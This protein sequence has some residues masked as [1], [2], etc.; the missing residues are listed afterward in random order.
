MAAKSAAMTSSYWFQPTEA[1]RRQ[2]PARPRLTVSKNLLKGT[3]EVSFSPPAGEAP[4]LWAVHVKR[5]GRWATQLWPAARTE[6]SLPY[7]LAGGA[8][9]LEVGAIDRAYQE[10][11]RAKIVIRTEADGGPLPTP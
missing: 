7:G 4:Y 8:E 6:I 9:A 2:P 5:G 11:P 1:Q 10:G 3:L